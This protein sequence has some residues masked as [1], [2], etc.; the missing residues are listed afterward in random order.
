M[1]ALELP[2]GPAGDC[3]GVFVRD[4]SNLGDLGRAFFRFDART[5]LGE[6]ERDAK[7]VCISNSCAY[8]L[9]VP[10]EAVGCLVLPWVAA[11]IA[12][13][14]AHLAAVRMIIEHVVH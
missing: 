14:Q 5:K 13:L 1:I 12:S 3:Q 2:V 4:I 8:F 6:D 11:G 7:P 10:C 9:L